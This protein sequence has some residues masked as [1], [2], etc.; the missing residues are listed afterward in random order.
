MS[1]IKSALVSESGESEHDSK[2]DDVF[3]PYPGVDWGCLW[4]AQDEKR[5]RLVD[6]ADTHGE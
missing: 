6:S 2:H 4:G 3:S 5:D 1:K